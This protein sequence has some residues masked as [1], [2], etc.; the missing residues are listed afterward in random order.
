[1]RN[2][3]KRISAVVI[4]IT[5]T[6]CSWT[7]NFMSDKKTTTVK[8]NQNNLNSN[9]A[10]LV[11]N[12]FLTESALHDAVRSNDL[13]LVK[14][15]IK[16]GI[17]KNTQDKYGYTPLHLAVRLHNYPITKYLIQQGANV[18]T[19][20]VY[21]D[22]PLLD[23]TRNDDTDISKEL[24]CN[25][26]NRNVSDR[27][28]MS[29]LHNSSKNKNQLITNLLRADNVNDLCGKKI[30]VQKV[31]SKIEKPIV[32]KENIIQEVNLGLKLD[33]AS[34]INDN[35][36]QI[37]GN[38]TQGDITTVRV[39]LKN[40]VQETFGE[41]NAKI[42]DD[43]SWCADV[44]DELANGNY[45]VIANGFDNDNNEAT[46]TAQTKIYVIEGL[47]NALMKEFKDDFEPWNAALDKDTLTFR[48][49]KPE[50]L[51]AKGSDT[52]RAKYRSIL[53]D[54]FPRYTKVLLNYKNE[55][56]NVRIEG[57]TSSEYSAG[58]TTDEKYKLNQILSD[59]RANTVLRYSKSLDH[60][61]VNNNITWINNIFRAKGFSSSQLIYNQDGT[62][63]QEKSRRVEFNII[64]N[65]QSDITLN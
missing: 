59:K 24:I 12:D 43:K 33:V 44:E 42:N 21:D 3:I 8:N 32:Q 38:I 31:K 22:T 49:E 27:H 9:K 53:S 4:L 65:N 29:T 16:Q 50:Y 26:A 25:G 58:K 30:I 19:H 37:C 62:E 6:G 52:L 56:Q 23:S 14:F 17:N 1:M 11:S 13:E 18:N 54:F 39:L 63:N 45:D 51:F 15:L 36:P 47:Y 61:I 5:I 2:Y 34:T 57:H 20:D 7:P 41:Y 40:E 64:T 35:K 48:F 55:I 10:T 60:R 28:D 46:D